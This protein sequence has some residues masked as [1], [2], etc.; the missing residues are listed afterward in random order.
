[1]KDFN[2]FVGY[3]VAEDKA[4]G[5]AEHSRIIAGFDMLCAAEDFISCC[6]KKRQGTRFFIENKAGKRWDC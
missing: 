4:K 2:F 5:I 1:M 3:T 6:L